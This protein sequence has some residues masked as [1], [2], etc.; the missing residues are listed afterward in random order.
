MS[1]DHVA[2]AHR[3]RWYPLVHAAIGVTR[4]T[5]RIVCSGKL[6]DERNWSFL[7]LT[8]AAADGCEVTCPVCLRR[9]GE[10]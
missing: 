10:R 5:V 2:Q 1:V 6:A 9:L 3:R 7:E 4:D 8:E